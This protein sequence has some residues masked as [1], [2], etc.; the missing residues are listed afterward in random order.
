MSEQKASD[1]RIFNLSNYTRPE[2]YENK[3]KDWVLNGRKNEFYNYII[4][5]YNGSPTNAAIINSYIDLIIGRGLVA[6]NSQNHLTEWVMFKRYLSSRDL[7]RIA[8]DFELF[9][10]A[11]IQIAKTKKGDLEGIYHIPKQYVVPQ[12]ENEDGEI[13]GYWYSKDFIRR[14]SN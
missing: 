10:E 3:S 6:N 7:R 9:G 12:I 13:E 2:I 11:S 4:D 14:A 8:S 1:V 5:R